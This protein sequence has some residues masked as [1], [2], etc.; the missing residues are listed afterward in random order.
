[1]LGKTVGGG[2]GRSCFQVEQIAVFLLVIAEALTHM[3]KHLLG[4]F[5]AA[6]VS[7]I[8]AEPVGIEPGFVHADKADGGEEISRKIQGVFR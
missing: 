6:G 8:T 1:M 3:I 5:L 4:K 7:H 2:L